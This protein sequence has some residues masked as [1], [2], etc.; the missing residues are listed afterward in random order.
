MLICQPLV[1]SFSGELSLGVV[2]SNNASVLRHCADE[3]ELGRAWHRYK[4][5]LKK[6]INRER[7]S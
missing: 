7:I 5:L 4:A 2:V 6:Q 3:N 1:F